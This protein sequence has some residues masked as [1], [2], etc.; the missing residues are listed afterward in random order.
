MKSCPRRNRP[1]DLVV[2]GADLLALA[3]ED[4]RWLPAAQRAQARGRQ[5]HLAHRPQAHRQDP[6]GLRS[7]LRRLGNE[8]RFIRTVLASSSSALRRCPAM[9]AGRRRPFSQR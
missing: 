9:P 2:L 8:A 5:R 1:P 6:E 3:R 4:T 7:W